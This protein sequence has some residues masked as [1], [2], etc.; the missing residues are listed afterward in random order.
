MKTILVPVDFTPTADN[1]IS[2]AVQ[3]S[4]VYGYEKIILLKSMYDSMFDDIIVSS[5][6]MNVNQDYRER[7]RVETTRQLKVQY[8]E[9]IYKV[10]PGLQV[11][12]AVSEDPLLR[13]IL[14]IIAE[15][16]PRL[17]II[18]SDHY[19]YSGNSFVGSNVISIAKISPVHILI[20]PSHY[21]YKPVERALVPVDFNTLDSLAKLDSYQA[22]TPFWK[23]KQLLVL[24]IDPEEKY[25]NKNEEFV[26]REN[27]LHH[28]LKNFKHEIYYS[29]E[30]DIMNG[31]IEFSKKH[32]VQ[33]IV[34][35]PGSHSFLY[36][37]THKSISE[38]I[39]RNAKEPILILK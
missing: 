24:N 12:F 29:N 6:F 27:S 17:L 3:W 1:A 36:L 11:F 14:Q 15:E 28:Y 16:K 20:V 26:D 37:L 31:I 7:D 10:A 5:D 23:E 18:G 32:D 39:Y 34:A 4:K 33:M 13:A 35:L 19:H 30:K 8:E 25:H 22:A 9:L 2:F 21:Q 38:A